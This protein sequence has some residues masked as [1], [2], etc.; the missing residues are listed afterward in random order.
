MKLN[1][2]MNTLYENTF[3]DMCLILFFIGGFLTLIILFTFVIAVI[4][5][6]LANRKWD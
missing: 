2:N 4:I 3:Y 5:S 1:Y 6:Y